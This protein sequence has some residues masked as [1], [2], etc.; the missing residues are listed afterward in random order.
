[1]PTQPQPTK[2]YAKRIYADR[3][4]ELLNKPTEEAVI[5][6]C[7]RGLIPYRRDGRRYFFFE[8]E[9]LEFLNTRPGVTLESIQTESR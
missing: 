3:A 5:M 7:K 8:E 4:K 6:A 1:M 9:L 2:R